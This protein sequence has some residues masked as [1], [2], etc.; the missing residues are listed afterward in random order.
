MFQSFRPVLNA[1]TLLFI[2]YQNF[3]SLPQKLL[4][5]QDKRFLVPSPNAFTYCSR[6]ILFFQ[7]SIFFTDKKNWGKKLKQKTKFRFFPKE[8]K[9]IIFFFG[10]VKCFNPFTLKRIQWECLPKRRIEF[11]LSIHEREEY[12]SVVHGRILH[13]QPKKLL[14]LKRKNLDT[15]LQKSPHQFWAQTVTNIVEKVAKQ[16]SEMLS[17]HPGRRD[18]M[19]SVNVH[20]TFTKEEVSS[21]PHL[22]MVDHCQQFQKTSKKQQHPPFRLQIVTKRA[23]SVEKHTFKSLKRDFVFVKKKPFRY[24]KSD[25]NSKTISLLKTLDVNY[26]WI[27]LLFF[28]SIR[29]G[30]IYS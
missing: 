7:F 30:R 9:N 11:L 15:S 25:Q 24:T 27:P 19:R 21:R 28:A 13:K 14:T 1:F 2:L 23:K 29:F 16:F 26:I 20:W 5:D 22:W 3:N 6:L 18:G 12:E 8:Q 10:G 17:Y 4:S